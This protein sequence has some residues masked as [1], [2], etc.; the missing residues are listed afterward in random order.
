VLLRRATAVAVLAAAFT[1]GGA[2]AALPS[3]PL[4]TS[5]TYPAAGLPAA[6]AGDIETALEQTARSLTGVRYGSVD[7][8]AALQW[9]GNPGH[10]LRVVVTATGELG[11][12]R[13]TSS[14]TRRIR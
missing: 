11:T 13:A 2:Q 3:D 12:V 5:W 6:S 4:A 10:R 8:F 14:P 7:A 1:A 9:L